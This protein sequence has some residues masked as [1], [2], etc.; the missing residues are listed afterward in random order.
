MRESVRDV[1]PNVLG[2]QIWASVISPDIITRRAVVPKVKPSQ[3]T[4]AVFWA[5]GRS[6]AV[7]VAETVLDFDV[8]AEVIED[9][10]QKLSVTACLVPRRIVY[11]LEDAFRSAGDDD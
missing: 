3:L 7:N 6:A 2:V 1:C 5:V 9:G 11:E 4:A 10:K 8:E